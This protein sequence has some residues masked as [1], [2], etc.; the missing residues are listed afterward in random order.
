MSAETGTGIERLEAVRFGLCRVDDFPNAY[1]HL[2]TKL[3]KF[4][5]E[6]DVDVAICV[7]QD[8]LHLGNRRRRNFVDI[9]LQHR[10]VHR[11][12]D[13]SRVC[14]D[15]SDDLGCV[16]CLIDQIAR[17][18]ALGTEAE[19]EILAALQAASLF[20]D[21]LDQ[22]FGGSRIGR[23]FKDDHRPLGQMF[24]NRD[25]A[26]ANIADIGLLM[27]VQRR[28]H[29]N[30]NKVDV[31]DERK[32]ARCLEHSLFD[33]SLEIGVYYVADI[34]VPFVDELHL[35]GLDVKPD[36]LEAGFRLFD[37]KRQTDIA[38]TDNAGNDRLIGDLFQQ[39]LF[40]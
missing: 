31:L 34:V 5:D 11:C 35:F 8:F 19:I 32:V 26:V 36:R 22:L 28:R 1:A 7:L 33:Q 24:G 6:T 2:V 30:R 23:R 21:R 14:A 3:R 10:S 13:F 38:E 18:D 17:I 12:N 37:R 15:R 25:R 4:I 16:F 9:A 29:A 27:R 20:E 40:H 39:F